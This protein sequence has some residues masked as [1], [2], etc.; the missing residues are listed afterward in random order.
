MPIRT[1]VGE[2]LGV[3]IGELAEPAA[4]DFLFLDAIAIVDEHSAPLREAILQERQGR[5]TDRVSGPA[6]LQGAMTTRKS[7]GP[8]GGS[9]RSSYHNTG[10]PGSGVET[11]GASRMVATLSSPCSEKRPR[12]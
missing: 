3:E 9:D 5:V 12:V 4:H 10:P 6:R 11:S 2:G 8:V 1:R 7:I